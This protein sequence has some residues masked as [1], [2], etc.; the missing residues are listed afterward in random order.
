MIDDYRHL[1]SKTGRLYEK[2]EAGRPEP[3]NLLSIV[4]DAISRESIDVFSIIR[5]PTRQESFN[6]ASILRGETEE[7]NLHSKFLKAL[8]DHRSEL[9][10]H[11][12]NLA[13]F[14]RLPSVEISNFDAD[15]AEVDEEFGN[16]DIVIHDSSSRQVVLVENRIRE[17]PQSGEISGYANQLKNQGFTPH[18][19]VLALDGHVH[20]E[21]GVRGLNY[22]CIYYRADLSPWLDRCR[23]RACN[24]PGLRESITQY[25]DLIAR[26][27]GMDRSEGYMNDLEKLCLK[28][29]NL[30]LVRDLKEAMVEAEVRLLCRLWREI[31]RRLEERIPDL[32]E[33]ERDVSDISEE[34]IRRFIAGRKCRWH[35]LFYRFAPQA[36]VGVVA[37][38]TI[39]F[40]VV[41][42]DKMG[43]AEYGELEKSLGRGQTGGSWNLWQCPRGFE[44]LN[45]RNPSREDLQMLAGKKERK[46]YVKEIVSGLHGVWGRVKESGVT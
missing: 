39:R 2:H 27:T 43:V 22:E 35:G 10:G 9:Y 38:N 16:I 20:S 21:K 33:L 4:L 32:P 30:V 34:T 26:M 42:S 40:G 13:D 31:A 25:L 28:K 8:L 29:G 41:C 19:R 3:F 12:A 44:Y 18:L 5:S 11:R 46:K 24:E 17:R 23:Q 1:L 36:F 6:V 7:I 15:S 14:L 45:L 37:E